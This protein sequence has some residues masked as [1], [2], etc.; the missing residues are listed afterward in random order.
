MDGLASAD[1]GVA[2]RGEATGSTGRGVYGLGPEGV[3]GESNTSSGT[4]VY[5]VGPALGYGLQ[6][7]N[8]GSL[9]TA[10]LGVADGA[11]GP[12]F[13]ISGQSSSPQ[14]RGVQGLSLYGSG[15]TYGV[16][17]E[18]FSPD[19]FGVFSVGD[20]GGTGA[21][22]FVQP[23][24]ADPSKEV[25][26]VCL[27][28]NES[29]TYFRGTTSLKDGKA[30]IEVPEEFRAVSAESGLTV[31][32]TAQGPGA[33]LWVE[34]QDLQR[35][36]VRGRGDV[37]FHYFVNGVRRGF[38]DIELVRENQ[39]FVPVLRG[40]PYG[41]QYP[42]ALRDILVENGILNPDYT[43]NEVTAAKLG[44]ELRDPDEVPGAD[45]STFGQH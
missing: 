28:G 38:Q 44:W 30:T 20:F 40:V 18:V 37:S 19:G 31:Q 33:D 42:Q 4:G 45:L 6:G 36:V 25:R 14:G 39:A 3:H 41:N 15:T 34:T 23:H 8:S 7:R 17:G 26:F 10:V 16:R 27:E 13:G 12:T 29:G 35:I 22:Y 1:G 43:P 24:P 5:G 21:K 32:V 2:L 11:A 9:G